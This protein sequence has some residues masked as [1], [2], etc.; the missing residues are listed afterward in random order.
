MAHELDFKKNGQAAMAYVGAKPWHSLGQELSKGASIDQWRIEAGMDYEV[1]RDEVKYDAEREINGVKVL[2]PGNFKGRDVLYRSDTGRP[3]SVVSSSYKVVQPAQ[4]LDF[5]AKLS[6]IGGFELETAGVLSGG[7]RI[8]GL[9]KVGDGAPVIGHDIVRPYVLFATSYDGTMAT[10]AK[11]SA[12]RVVCNNTITMAVGRGFMQDGKTE[13]DTENMAVSTQV[14]IP[15]SQSVDIDDIRQKLGIVSDV[16]EKWMVQTRLMAET[17]VSEEFAG[18]FLAELVGNKN[19][20]KPVE[21]TKAYKRIMEIFNGD[22]IGY[23]DAGAANRWTLV[24]AVTQY[25]DHER[26]GEKSRLDSAWFGSGNA[27]KDKAYQML[28]EV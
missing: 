7:K 23:E 1:K 6:E 17:P 18:Q 10:T 26:G 8:W 21:E 19:S 20:E 9:A 4:I 2:L 13:K 28:A 24:N 3:L 15:H 25:I 14:R 27:L 11:F 12:I 5:F 22:M 16:Y